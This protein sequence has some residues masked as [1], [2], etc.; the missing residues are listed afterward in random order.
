[1]RELNPAFRVS[2]I[3]EAMTRRRAEDLAGVRGS[4]ANCGVTGLKVNESSCPLLGV[5]RTSLFAVQMSA[6][7]PKR[8]FN[9]SV[10]T[11]FVA[12]KDDAPKAN[13][14]AIHLASHSHLAAH[15]SRCAARFC[16][17]QKGKR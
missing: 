16:V 6:F 5:K 8:T 13:T 12:A 11:P 14:A 2:N 7:D 10:Y 15:R 1:M 9:P 3:K 17:D 4:I